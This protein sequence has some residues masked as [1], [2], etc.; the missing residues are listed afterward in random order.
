MTEGIL[1]WHISEPIADG[2]AAE[3][4]RAFKKTLTEVETRIR[5]FVLVNEKEALK[6]PAA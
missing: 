2:D 4:K 3:K 5:L 1:Q 6:R